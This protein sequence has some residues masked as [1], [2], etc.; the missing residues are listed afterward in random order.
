MYSRYLPL[1]TQEEQKI[2]EENF[3]AS[4]FFPGDIVGLYNEGQH[5]EDSLTGVVTTI[6]NQSITIALDDTFESVDQEASYF[7]AKLANDVTYKRLKKYDFSTEEC[8]DDDELIVLFL[9]LLTMLR[10]LVLSPFCT[11]F[12]LA[13]ASSVFLISSSIPN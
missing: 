5:P 9:V 2:K 6:T 8:H 4:F 3:H 13:N 11:I 10:T 7:I 12:S 1:I